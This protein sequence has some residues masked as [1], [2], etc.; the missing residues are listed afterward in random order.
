MTSRFSWGFAAL[1]CLMLLTPF[2]GANDMMGPLHHHRQCS[3]CQVVEE[4]VYQDVV[5]QRCKLVPDNKPI[6]KTVYEIKE[7]PVCQK[8]LPCFLG[9]D[10]CPECEC[11]ARTKRVLIK[12]EIVCGEKEGTKCVTEE[13]IERVPVKVQRVIPCESCQANCP[14]CQA[15]RLPQ[16]ISEVPVARTATLPKVKTAVPVAPVVIDDSL[17]R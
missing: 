14:A 17:S 6:K 1:S 5:V 2:I 15:A 16:P 10:D 13:V 8:K 9:C 11:C 7:V 12:K 4:I 3:K